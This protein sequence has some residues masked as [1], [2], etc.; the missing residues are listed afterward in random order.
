[1]VRQ[2]KSRAAGPAAQERD[3]TVKNQESERLTVAAV[4]E[5]RLISILAAALYFMRP[6]ADNPEDGVKTVK[7][8][9]LNLAHIAREERS[10]SEPPAPFAAASPQSPA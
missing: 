6:F 5:D 7:R 9:L 8:T 1:M 4:D 10:F 3:S 2:Q